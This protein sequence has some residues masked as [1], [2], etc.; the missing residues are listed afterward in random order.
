MFAIFECGALKRRVLFI[1]IYNLLS[2]FIAIIWFVI[3]L[4][5]N[6]ISQVLSLKTNIFLITLLRKKVQKLSK[7]RSFL[8][9]LL[10]M[11]TLVVFPNAPRFVIR[12]LIFF[13]GLFLHTT[14]VFKNLKIFFNNFFTFLLTSFNWVRIISIRG[15][16]KEKFWLDELN[17]TKLRILFSKSSFS[18]SKAFNWFA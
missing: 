15:W 10:P 7:F 13:H 9:L 11:S 18:L 16:I 2:K 1:K 3:K 14:E 12:T 8:S 4:N 6:S 5:A 17:D